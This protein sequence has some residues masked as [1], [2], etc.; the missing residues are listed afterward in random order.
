MSI[1]TDLTFPS[2]AYFK[3]HLLNNG[4]QRAFA[5][6][7]GRRSECHRG[8]DHDQVRIEDLWLPFICI[9]T[10]IVGFKERVHDSG[11]LWKAVRASMSLAGFVSWESCGCADVG[12]YP[13]D[14]A[15]AR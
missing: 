6:V 11:T 9:S 3:G 15:N 2:T 10:D 8:Y 7:R 13:K 4:L 5:Q 14:T 1:L 12:V